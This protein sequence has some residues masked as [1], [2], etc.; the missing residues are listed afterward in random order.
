MAG[1]AVGVVDDGGEA[2]GGGPAAGIPEFAGGGAAGV[3]GA[4]GAARLGGL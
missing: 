3:A 1:G 2:F 4:G